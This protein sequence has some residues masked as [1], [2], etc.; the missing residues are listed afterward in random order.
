MRKVYDDDSAVF[1]VYID[2]ESHRFSASP[3]DDAAI[4]E[5]EETLSWRGTF[6]V[7]EPEESVWKY[8]MQSDEMT[9]YLNKHGIPHARRNYH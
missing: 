6:R 1:T 9:A 8:L 5:Y 3:V 2:E 7:S 4:I